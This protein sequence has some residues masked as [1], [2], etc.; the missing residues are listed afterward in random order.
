MLL[1]TVPPSTPVR[2]VVNGRA[3]C[4]CL[5]EMVKAKVK[6]DT[7]S[8]NAAISGCENRGQ[9]NAASLLLEAMPRAEVLPNVI[10]YTATISA[11]E[12]ASQ[13]EAAL[14]FFGAMAAAG[15]QLDTTS[16]NAAITACEKGGKVGGSLGVVQG[17][18][19]GQGSVERH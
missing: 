6:H 9:W 3:H 10:S 16:Y 19:H 1:A 5:G 2:R 11:C 4:C 14:A 15:V 7:I 17:H 8:Y 13:W 18:G 12:K